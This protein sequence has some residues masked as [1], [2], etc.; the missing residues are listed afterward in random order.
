MVRIIVVAVAVWLAFYSGRFLVVDR[1]QK[2]DA[3]VV[4]GGDW[5]DVRYWRGR[6]LLRDGY[7]P[8]MFL[9]VSD[10]IVYGRKMTDLATEFVER[11]ASD[12][13]GRVLVCPIQSASTLKETAYV[14]SCLEQQHAR[15]ALLV[16]SDFHTRRAYSTFRHRLP[17]YQWSIAAAYDGEAFGQKWWLLRQWAK[18]LLGE[19]QRLLWWIAATL[20]CASLASKASAKP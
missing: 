15:S 16:T 4:L 14:Q 7:A 18:T 17:Q 1:P 13:P 3:I 11:T 6:E 8:V 20:E 5:D 19:H 2:S 10:D 9:D 12:S